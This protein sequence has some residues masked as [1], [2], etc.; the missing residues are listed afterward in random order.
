MAVLT[1]FQNLLK[2]ADVLLSEEGIGLP[3]L[4]VSWSD[5]DT[6]NLRDTTLEIMTPR[7]RRYWNGWTGR[8]LLYTIVWQMRDD[9][10]QT[11][12]ERIRTHA[13]R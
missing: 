3:H 12:R 6:V 11:M 5:I 4:F 9:V 7:L 2:H 10:L 8:L 1:Y 13:A